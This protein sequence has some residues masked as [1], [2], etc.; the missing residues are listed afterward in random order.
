M[1]RAGARACARTLYT[2]TSDWVVR[3]MIVDIDNTPFKH[4]MPAG[5]LS[6]ALAKIS[7]SRTISRQLRAELKSAISTSPEKGLLATSHFLAS[8][9]VVLAAAVKANRL[10]RERKRATLERC[11]AMPSILNV[12][13]PLQEPS[14][15]RAHPKHS[16]GVRVTHD[17]GLQ[18]RTSQGMVL[19]VM[20]CHFVP[21]PFQYTF[22]GIHEAIAQ[23]KP[24]LLQGL[25]YFATL[26]IK[27]H[28]GSFDPEKLTSVLPLPKEW[29]DHA[30]VGR[31]LAV[32]AEKNA[33]GKPY[34]IIPTHTLLH[35]ARQGVPQGSACSPIVAAFCMAHLQWESLPGAAMSNYGD[36]FLLLASSTQVLDEC[37]GKLAAAI[38]GLPGGH[39][40]PKIIQK[41]HAKYGV[42]YLGHRLV[43]KGAQVWISI[44]P[45]NQ[46]SI[47]GELKRLDSKLD[48]AYMQGGT[49]KTEQCLLR[50]CAYIKGWVRAFRECDDV[51]DW[52]AALLEMTQMNAGSLGTKVPNIYATIGENYEFSIQEYSLNM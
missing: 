46:E 9:D 35:Q 37:I 8:S 5:Q 33:A 47:L 14:F 51:D 4:S 48:H 39:F 49:F 36:N 19:R 18:H 1:L 17:F 40:Q 30:V 23:A 32:V 20:E 52:E 44:S 25:V 24:L 7:S 3:A 12:Q 41:G 28:F 6:K 27:D 26:D 15:V 16:E 11:L 21:R 10:I 22:R 42:D 34:A 45:A 31:H 2:R 29:V 50:M 43:G 13:G 38:A